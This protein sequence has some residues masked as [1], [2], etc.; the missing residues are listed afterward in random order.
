MEVFG[1]H[2]DVVPGIIVVQGQ[3]QLAGLPYFGAGLIK[4]LFGLFRIIPVIG[5]GIGLSLRQV[6]ELLAGIV[7]HTEGRY[8]IR[9]GRMVGHLGQCFA[10]N[11]VKQRLAELFASQYRLFRTGTIDFNLADNTVAVGNHSGVFLILFVAFRS[12]LQA[13]QLS[14]FKH[15]EQG[16]VVVDNLHYNLVQID[17]IGM[18][19]IGILFKG[20]LVALGPAGEDK[21]PVADELIRLGAIQGRGFGLVH[22]G[23]VHIQP[24]RRG[25]AA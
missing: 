12:Q 9:G 11:R 13:V 15:L 16:A 6:A 23:L 17:I 18:E 8:I 1:H 7:S 25:N 24:D 20:S 14:G 21:G 3:L 19:I 10:V 4:E 5:R 2:L 22:H